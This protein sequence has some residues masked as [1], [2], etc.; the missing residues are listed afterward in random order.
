MISKHQIERRF[1]QYINVFFHEIRICNEQTSPLGANS[2]TTMLKRDHRDV[3]REGSRLSLVKTR[4]ELK[5]LKS[6]RDPQAKK[7]QQTNKHK[8]VL[9]LVV[10]LDKLIYCKDRTISRIICLGELR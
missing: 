3:K 7:Q 4:K 1:I 10:Y 5:I 6:L 8:V 2:R 9:K